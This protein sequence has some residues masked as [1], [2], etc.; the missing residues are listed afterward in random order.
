MTKRL[1]LIFAMLTAFALLAAALVGLVPRGTAAEADGYSWSVRVTK[2]V[3]DAYQDLGVETTLS[4]ASGVTIL[5]KNNGSDGD[6][7]SYYS[8]STKIE[9]SALPSK[10]SGW[11]DIE[12][13]STKVVYSLELCIQILIGLV[14]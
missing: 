4:D 3:D 1:R 9:L 14:S 2:Y 11:S 12:S 6:N 13:S 5:I 10:V 8:S 7:F